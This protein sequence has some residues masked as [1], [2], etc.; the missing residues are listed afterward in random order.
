MAGSSVNLPELEDLYRDLRPY[1]F[2]IAYRMLGSVSEAEDVVQEAFVR[3][4]RTTEEKI[5]SPK[6]YLATVTTST[7]WS[8]CS[9]ATP[10]STATAAARAP[11]CH[12]RSTAAT[13]S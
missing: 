11:A 7:G 6:A 4:S 12:I 9:P 3:L 10:P 1:G 8:R 13:T 5:G 2:A